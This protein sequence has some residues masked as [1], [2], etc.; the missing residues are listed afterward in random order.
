MT[1]L[2]A[3]PLQLSYFITK[4]RVRAQYR[5]FLKGCQGLEA[6]G[7]ASTAR[8]VRAR[9]KDAFRADPDADDFSIR[10]RLAA[11]ERDLKLLQA[12]AEDQKPDDVAHVVWPWQE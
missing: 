6:R 9:V 11:G 5:A 1:R 4:A 3:V 2:S 7:N 12:L 10:Q 8:D